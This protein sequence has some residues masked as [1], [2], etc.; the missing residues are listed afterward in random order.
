MAAIKRMKSFTQRDKCDVV[1]SL[2]PTADT[3]PARVKLATCSTDQ[4]R[5]RK[6]FL[7]REKTPLPG[8]FPIH[9]VAT[10]PCGAEGSFRPLLS[11]REGCTPPRSSGQSIIPALI[12]A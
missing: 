10:C 7:F 11:S 1:L 9:L 12:D 3:P 4:K 6:L 2:G 8:F 5:K